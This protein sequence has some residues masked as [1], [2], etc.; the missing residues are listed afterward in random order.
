VLLWGWKAPVHFLARLIT[1]AS[2][3]GIV[4]VLSTLA[5]ILAS[6]IFTGYLV[7]LFVL[8]ALSFV[9][10]LPMR[11]AHSFWLLYRRIA[12]HC[13]YDDC[14][15]KGMPIHICSC[16]EW[17]RDL[18][19][20]FYGIFYHNCRHESR[21]EKLPTMDLF[22][23]NRL[24]R[25][26][27]GCQRPLIHSALGELPVWPIFAV[28]GPSTGKT[29]FLCQAVRQLQKSLSDEGVTVRIDSEEQQHA[30]E[31]Q[32]ELLDRGQVVAKTAG[33]IMQ[34][35]GLAVRARKQPRCLLYLFD[36]PGENFA[37]MKRFGHMQALQ[38]LKGIVLLMDPFSMPTLM[39]QSGL[40]ASELKPSETP[41]RTVVDNLINS[42][43]MMLLERPGDKCKVPLAVVLSK[44]DALPVESCPFLANLVPRDGRQA[45]DNLNQRCRD[46]LTKLGEGR[47]IQE[48]E[49]KFSDVRYFACSALGR[50]PDLRNPRPFQPSGVVPPLQW[51]L[52]RAVR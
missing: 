32:M 25:L 30:L 52:S 47:S 14:S 17:Y 18:K 28:G 6:V 22:G 1:G 34:A 11:A 40:S 49:W 41:F 15:F 42:V 36:E 29:L 35:F 7:I 37:T 44:A 16:G 10:F 3:A 4:L 27:G 33:D 51:I 19:P 45:D 8:T 50:T 38:N 12:Y 20:S 2:A 23:R 31:Q 21:V 39:E 9:V 46:A 43:N 26:C 5:V 13:A 24:P 48:L